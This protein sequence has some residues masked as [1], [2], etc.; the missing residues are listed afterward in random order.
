[1]QDD[2]WQNFVAYR[3]ADDQ[4]GAV[5][6]QLYAAPFVNLEFAREDSGAG[7]SSPDDVDTDAF[8]HRLW[9]AAMD[10]QYVTFNNTGTAG[11]KFPVDPK[12]ADSPGAKQ[13]TIWYEFFANTR[14]WELEPY[15]D[16]DGGRAVAEEGVEYIV[17]VEK[18][19]GPIEV[20]VDKHGYDVIWL[21]P[22]T[23]ES[24]RQ[25]KEFK[26]ERFTGSAPDN[27][28]DWV[29]HLSR[30]G[31]KEGM[32]RSI[33][34]DSREMPL[35]LQDIEI[36]PTKVPFEIE[37]PTAG[38]NLRLSMAAPFSVKMKRE[39]RATRAMMYLWLGEVAA[40]GQGYRVIGTGGK[41]TLRIPPGIAKDF[42]RI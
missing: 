7:K 23:G 18:P 19:A 31:H 36:N 14:H 15:F 25:K 8:R 3:T 21:N 34:F 1:M 41:G 22:I 32:L 39:T 11:G 17:Y 20:E 10:G 37:R 35:A 4:V 5:E 26:G 16:V 40:S 9:N 28:H 24:V 29:L 27:S 42:P 30:E 38:V 2:G 6:H 13:M 33:K 12:Y